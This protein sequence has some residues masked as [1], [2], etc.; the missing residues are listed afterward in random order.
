MQYSFHP[1]LRTRTVVPGLPGRPPADYLRLAMVSSLARGDVFFDMCVQVQT[2]PFL[3]P[4]ENSAVMWPTSLSP[5]VP[6]A[7]VRIP[8]QKFDSPAQ[9]SFAR[10]LSFNPWHCLPEHRPLGNINRA[11]KRLYWEMSQLRQRMN[12]VAHYEPNGDETFS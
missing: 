7:I 6:V 8:R 9:I 11:R 10:A 2:D 5:R 1:R 12:G 3:M 4:I